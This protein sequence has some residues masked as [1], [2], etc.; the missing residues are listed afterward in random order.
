MLDKLPFPDCPNKFLQ[1]QNALY[2][3]IVGLYLILLI[4]LLFH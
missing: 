2:D 3:Y 1:H 4:I